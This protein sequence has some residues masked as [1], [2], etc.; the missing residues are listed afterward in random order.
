MVMCDMRGKS[1]Q[2]SGGLPNLR[3]PGSWPPS[4]RSTTSSFTTTE[5]RSIHLNGFVISTENGIEWPNTA[6]ACFLCQNFQSNLKYKY[7]TKGK[8]TIVENIESVLRFITTRK[9]SITWN[10]T[11]FRYLFKPETVRRTF[12]EMAYCISVYE[13][14]DYE[15]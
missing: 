13:E 2:L 1:F 9:L 10:L 14:I 6:V 3:L 7:N 15:L 4:K 12:H 11:N 5:R 8:Y